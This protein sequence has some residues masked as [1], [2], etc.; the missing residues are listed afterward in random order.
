MS[1]SFGVV[2][3]G[4]GVMGSGFG[5]GDCKSFKRIALKRHP[6][7]IDYSIPYNYS[8]SSTEVTFGISM[9]IGI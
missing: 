6:F 7:I 4:G 9:V 3:Y 2:L 8:L 1:G 5:G